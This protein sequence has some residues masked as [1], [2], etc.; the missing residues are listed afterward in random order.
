MTHFF[1]LP[2]SSSF[3]VI[4]FKLERF[5]HQNQ[6]HGN[7]VE[8]TLNFVLNLLKI[9]GRQ[10]DNFVV[11]K[12]D[13]VC[14]C[15]KDNRKENNGHLCLFVCLL[16]RSHSIFYRCSLS[17]TAIVIVIL[18]HFVVALSLFDKMHGTLKKRPPLVW[19]V[20]WLIG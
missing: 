5:T 18:R 9:C 20:G 12:C 16:A 6:V 1:S 17:S 2:V 19:L 15:L 11:I 4:T 10:T 7:I 3:F 14:S 13:C 8:L